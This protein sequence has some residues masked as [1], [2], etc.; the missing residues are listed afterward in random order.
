MRVS[1]VAVGWCLIFAH[2]LGAQQ[3]TDGQFCDWMKEIAAKSNK[4]AGAKVD[5]MTTNL[6]MA[7]LCNMKVIDFKKRLDVPMS[8]LAAG[9]E[10]R[11]Q[12]QWNEIY[13]NNIAFAQAIAAGWTISLTLTSV[14]G[15]RHYM[16][17]KCK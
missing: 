1:V 7:V 9:W 13:C 8:N 10:E 14:D 11:K 6:G 2:P 12:S 5:A 15:K 17:A 4:D 3:F 16:E